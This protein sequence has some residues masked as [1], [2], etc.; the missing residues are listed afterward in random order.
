[1]KEYP[2][3]AWDEIEL[4]RNLV[5]AEQERNEDLEEERSQLRIALTAIADADLRRTKAGFLAKIAQCALGREVS[6][7]Y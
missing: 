1:M 3:E 6:D 5:S 2:S 4:L 7:V